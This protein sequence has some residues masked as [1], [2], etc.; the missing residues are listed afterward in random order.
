[1][2]LLAAEYGADIVYGEELVDKRV[3]HCQRVENKTLNTVDFTDKNDKLVFRTC[4]EEHGRMVFQ[5]GTGDAGTTRSALSI[6][7]KL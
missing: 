5:I 7:E 4:P 2:R 6:Y 3:M 1:M